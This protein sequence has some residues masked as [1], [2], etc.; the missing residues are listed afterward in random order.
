VGSEDVSGSA[1]DDTI[2]GNDVIRLGRHVG[3]DRIDEYIRG[4]NLYRWRRGDDRLERALMA[5]S[6]HIPRLA[7]VEDASQSSWGDGR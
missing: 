7:M 2:K 3:D 1:Y 6:K 4:S 5:A